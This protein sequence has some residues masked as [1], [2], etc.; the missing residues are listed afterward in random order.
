MI[1][2]AIAYYSE[3]STISEMLVALK[4]LHFPDLVLLQLDITIKYID[5]FGKQLM[6]LLKGLKHEA[7]AA[8]IVS[9]LEVISGEFYTLKLYAMVRN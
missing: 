1:A 6:D 7:L 8:T 5:V 4:G 9:G 3:T 2:V